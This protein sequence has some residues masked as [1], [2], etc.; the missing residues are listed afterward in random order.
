MDLIEFEDKRSLSREEAAAVLRDLADSLARH[1]GL[2][3]S[4]EGRRYTVE[5]PD[6]VEIEVELEIGDDGSTL[7]IEIS[8]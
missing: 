6:Q 1:N 8:W 4:K 3:F 5:V 7:E 2:E